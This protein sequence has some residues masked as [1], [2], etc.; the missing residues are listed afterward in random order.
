MYG[1]IRPQRLSWL[2]NLEGFGLPPT[3]P[4]DGPARYAKWLDEL[5]EPLRQGRYRSVAQ[6]AALLRARNSRLPPERATLIAQA[7]TRPVALTPPGSGVEQRED[8]VE[9]LFDPRHRL[10]NPVLYRRQEAEAC[11]ARIAAPVLL[12]RGGVED[13]RSGAMRQISGEVNKHVRNM[14]GVTV[15]SAGHMLHH[16]KPEEV[17]RHIAEFERKVR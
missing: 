1:G 5:R 8:E 12:M 16:E 7:W 15:A 17:A 13:G 14:H 11:W 10:G 4:R 6:L 3:D 2:V 9:L